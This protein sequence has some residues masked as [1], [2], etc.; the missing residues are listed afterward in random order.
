MATQVAYIIII[1]SKLDKY[2]H[3][4]HKRMMT[5]KGAEMPQERQAAPCARNNDTRLMTKAFLFV[6]HILKRVP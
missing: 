3:I 4:T 5:R 2:L 1:P 6:S